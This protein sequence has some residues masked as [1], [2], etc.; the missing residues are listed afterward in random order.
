MHHSCKDK[1]L[2]VEHVN[3]VNGPPTFE[4]VA[5]NSSSMEN[6]CLEFNSLLE[7]E[8]SQLTIIQVQ[9]MFW[10]LHNRV[11]IC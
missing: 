6:V 3:G 2:I 5:R 7:N 11:S 9:T 10:K 8:I 4:N 1:T